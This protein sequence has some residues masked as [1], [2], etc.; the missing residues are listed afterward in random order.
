MVKL[1]RTYPVWLHL[2]HLLYH[3]GMVVSQLIGF[4]SSFHTPDD[5]NHTSEFSGPGWR[6]RYVTTWILSIL[7]S[8]MAA[9]LL[10]DLILLW[11]GVNDVIVKRLK[12]HL[13][14]FFV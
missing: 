10:F 7:V 5:D 12:I 4:V 11:K 8:Y 1:H 9:A 13:D 14:R 3:G 6:F 2:L